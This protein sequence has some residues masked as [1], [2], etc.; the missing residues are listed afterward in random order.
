[1]QVSSSNLI[2]LVADTLTLFIPFLTLVVV[3]I[4]AADC[5]GQRTQLHLISVLGLALIILSGACR[6]ALD[7]WIIGSDS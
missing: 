4:M 3:V 2:V 7:F 5:S 1:M 6:V